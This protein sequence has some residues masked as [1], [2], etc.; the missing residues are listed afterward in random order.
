VYLNVAQNLTPWLFEARSGPLKAQK[1]SKDERKEGGFGV[2]CCYSRS[3][4]S[5][6]ITGGTAMMRDTICRTRYKEYFTL[7]LDS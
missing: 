3:Y 1:A 6:Y 7:T 2:S 4:V 5:G